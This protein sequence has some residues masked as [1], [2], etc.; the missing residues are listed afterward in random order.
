VGVGDPNSLYLLTAM[1]PF[2]SPFSFY[3]QC[4]L[5]TSDMSQQ[6]TKEQAGIQYQ[7]TTWLMKKGNKNVLAIRRS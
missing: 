2:F 3:K 1:S 5:Q 6:S 4:N 7:A